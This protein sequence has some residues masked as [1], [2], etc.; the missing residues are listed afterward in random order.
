MKCLLNRP[1]KVNEKG[2][3]IDLKLGITDII[4][5]DIFFGVFLGNKCRHYPFWDHYNKY[6]GTG[7]VF[8]IKNLIGLRLKLKDQDFK[9]IITLF[10]LSI[11][12]IKN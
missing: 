9:L 2:E 6:I 7:L 5:I 4:K 1:A 11:F 10:G 12:L 8:D 3:L